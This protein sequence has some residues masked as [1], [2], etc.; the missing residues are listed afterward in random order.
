MLLGHLHFSAYL[1]AMAR[2]M[3]CFLVMLQFTACTVSYFDSGHLI[4]AGN[5]PVTVGFT[6]VEDVIV[7]DA[8]IN[9]IKGKFLLDNGFSLSAVDPE[10]AQ[11][12]NIEFKDK[13]TLRDANNQRLEIAKTLVD[14]V[15]IQGHTF[16]GTGFYEVETSRFFPCYPI[17]GVIGASIMNKINWELDFQARQIRISSRPFKNQ[18]FRW[19]VDFINN[20]SSIVKLSFRGKEAKAKIDLGSS[21]G[22]KLD[23]AHFQKTFSGSQVIKRVGMFS[24]SAAGLGNVDTTYQSI[25]EE[26]VLFEGEPLPVDTRIGLNYNLKYP[27]YIGLEYLQNYHLTINSTTGHYILSPVEDAEEEDIQ[28]YGLALYK[29]E[30]R[31]QVI[32]INPNDTLLNEVRLLDEVIALDGAPID[33]FPDICAYK[34]YLKEKA[35]RAETLSIALKSSGQSIELPYRASKTMN[36]R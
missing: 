23:M 12:A 20:N 30:D 34:T 19:K 28:S 26:P 27:A 29:I 2:Y 17:D 13:G 1:A 25:A 21:S 24:L 6:M 3:L 10:F 18:G 8:E 4:P 7:I 36:L 16:V 5:E 15:R 35:E 9:G 33:R 22:I 14:T 31:W 32:Q 11:R